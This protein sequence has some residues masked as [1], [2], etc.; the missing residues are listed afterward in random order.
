MLSLGTAF[1]AARTMQRPAAEASMMPIRQDVVERNVVETPIMSPVPVADGSFAVVELF[2]SEGCSSCPPADAVLH[3]LI[4]EAR[5]QGTPVIPIAFHV[6]YWNKL[7]WKDPLSNIVFSERQFT[8]GRSLKLPS[9]YTPQMIVNGN[10]EFVGSDVEKARE[11]IK[12]A[13]ARA[14]ETKVTL[15]AESIP[16]DEKI[17][18]K[19]EVEGT[20]DQSDMVN[21]VL[22]ER[23]IETKVRSGENAGHTL[24]HENVARGLRSFSLKR[25]MKGEVTFNPP[26]EMSRERAA[27]VA[28]VQDK[29]TMAITGATMLDLP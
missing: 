3:K 8:Y 21:I 4:D 10:T 12:A 9:V 28:Y 20:E 15:Q 16:G 2:T 25:G 5:E 17:T 6:D 29:E 27:V 18:V 24:Q 7:G 22:I 13:L 23:Q 26:T 11:S 1:A 19:Y 14:A